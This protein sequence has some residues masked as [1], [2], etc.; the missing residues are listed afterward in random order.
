[1]TLK[2][3]CLDC[4]VLI[5]SGSRCT[6]C[7]SRWE[8]DHRGTT[9]QRGYGSTWQKT[10]KRIIARDKGECQPRLPVCTGTATT[11]DHVVAKANGGT[12]DDENLVAACLRCNSSKR[13]RA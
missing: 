9:S 11:A 7:R 4:G 3:P 8:T 5:P 13:D 10:S 12:D 6:R 1:M 2:R